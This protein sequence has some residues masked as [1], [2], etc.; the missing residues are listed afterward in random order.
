MLSVE[1]ILVKVEHRP[2]W[3]YTLPPMPPAEA[4][5]IWKLLTRS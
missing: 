5:R 2:T 1:P 3:S 4:A